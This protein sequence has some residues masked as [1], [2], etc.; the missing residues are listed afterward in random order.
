MKKKFFIIALCFFVLPQTS[1]ASVFFV[2]PTPGVLGV[3]A[4]LAL[5]VYIDTEEQHINTVG[6]AIIIPNTYIQFLEISD[7]GSIVSAWIERPSAS[8]TERIAFSGIIPGGYKGSHGLLF[9]I[10]GKALKPGT[11]EV[12]FQDEESYLANGVGT[13]VATHG[14]K[15]TLTIITTSA[16]KYEDKPDID[17]PEHFTVQRARD[18]HVFNNQ[19]FIVFNTQDKGSGID[20]YEIAETP[21]SQ[22]NPQFVRATSPVVLHDQTLRSLVYVKAVDRAGNERTE[23]LVP[24]NQKTNFYKS[25]FWIILIG[26]LL[27]GFGAFVFVRRNKNAGS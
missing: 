6:G 16:E 22:A 1:F 10:L 9:T 15:I 4:T 24:A 25:S 26:I 13:Q 19:W 2:E 11:P 12:Y 14:N 5:H 21:D 23:P 20:H 18:I 17:S 27:I 8:N 7:A 3:G